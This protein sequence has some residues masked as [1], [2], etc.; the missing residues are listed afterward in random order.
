MLP[1]NVKLNGVPVFRLIN[2]KYVILRPFLL[3]T[4]LKYQNKKRLTFFFDISEP[5]NTKFQLLSVFSFD[6]FENRT[7]KSP[8]TF[9]KYYMY[10]LSHNSFEYNKLSLKLLF[11]SIT[12]EKMYQRPRCV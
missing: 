2:A 4:W 12:L 11:Q 7:I 10:F 3:L 1:F 5:I 9:L 8:L 6:I